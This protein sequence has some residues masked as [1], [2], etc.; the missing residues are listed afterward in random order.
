MLP[1]LSDGLAWDV[2][3]Q[4]SHLTATIVDSIFAGDYNVNGIVDAADFTI[5]R[6]NFGSTTNLTADGNDD[7]VV[8]VADY[9]VWRDNF[10]NTWGLT[11]SELDVMMQVP[12]PSCYPAALAVLGYL[13]WRR[14]ITAR[15]RT[16]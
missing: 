6:D 9:L 8:D 12:E 4:N 16:T 1:T 5:W 3:Y 11:S 7:G 14:R 13:P 2:A 10:G 15:A